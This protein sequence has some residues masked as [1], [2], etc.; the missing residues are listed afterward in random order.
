[1]AVPLGTIIYIAVKPIFKIYMIIG[2]GVLLARL[3]ILSMRTSRDLSSIA[4]NVLLP[5]LIF[6]KIVTN[7]SNTDIKEIATIVVDAFFRM[8]SSAVCTF[9]LG[10]LLRCRRDWYGGL[11]SIGMLI[12]I[13][14]LP[15]AYLQ[16]MG[17]SDLLHNVDKG[18]SYV[19]IYMAVQTIV[20][21]N[22]GVFKLIGLDFRNKPAE[23]NEADAQD[24][25]V[26][27]SGREQ[28][29]DGSA[30]D[31]PVESELKTEDSSKGASQMG[32]AAGE[33]FMRDSLEPNEEP[34]STVSSF[35]FASTD[36]RSHKQRSLHGS[37]TKAI[38]SAGTVALTPNPSASSTMSG[39]ISNSVQGLL[40]SPVKSKT[41]LCNVVEETQQR[42]QSVV[43]LSPRVGSEDNGRV[44]RIS[45]VR[46]RMQQLFQLLWHVKYGKAFRRAVVFMVSSTSRP[47][48]ITIIVSIVICMIPWVKALFVETTQAHIHPAPDSLP[49]LSFIMDFASYVGAA[50][51][52]I[53]LLMLGG[54]IGRISVVNLSPE[55]WMT[56]LGVSIFKLFV[57]PVIGCAF[58]SKLHK[59]GL[60]YS[61][62]V[63]YFI[64]NVDFCLPPSTTNFYVTAL[65]TPK[66]SKSTPQVDCLALAYLFHYIFL[67][68]CLP[69]V[70]TYTMKVP[71]GY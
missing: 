9:L 64:S 22:F 48:S 35:E 29:R 43:E 28:K 51:V 44:E 19:C 39:G 10:L 20:Q 4:V 6:D 12:N 31:S 33:P 37:A 5:C 45:L 13:S 26:S 55:I 62:D 38:T 66:G 14:D 65:Y 42:E 23:K 57:F 15:I 32:N 70:S 16:S 41:D 3:D 67:A 1:M 49:P 56:P 2:V 68:F 60:F 11:L 71:L 17:D 30:G 59:D 36:S 25:E 24:E 47:I 46:D 40:A 58:N 63:L 7:I 50:Q 8:G 52:P 61:E 34:T 18:V 21:F 53:G 69:F 27:I 54:T